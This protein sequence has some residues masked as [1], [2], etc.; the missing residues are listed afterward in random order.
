MAL[1]SLGGI[2]WAPSPIY[3]TPPAFDTSGVL[4]A[5]ADRVAWI[6]MCDRALTVDQIAVSFGA[7]ATPAT[8]SFRIETL[9]GSPDQPSGA[10]WATN[11]EATPVTPVANSVVTGTLTANASIGIRTAFAVVVQS[12][13]TPINVIINRVANTAPLAGQFPYGATNLT[14]SYSLSATIPMIGIHD[15]IAGWVQLGEY[16]LPVVSFDGPAI[17]TGTGATTGTRRGVR[18]SIP[19]PARLA[20]IHPRISY[21]TNA[22]WDLILYD[23][24]GGA[25]Q[26]MLSVVGDTQRSSGGGGGFELPVNPYTIAANT[27][28]KLAIVPTTANSVTLREAT[29]GSG[30]LSACP[31]GT[32]WQST[33]YISSAWSVITDSHPFISLGFDQVDNGASAG[34]LLTHP[35]MAGGMR[36]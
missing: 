21:L 19:V 24:S 14:G 34:G 36:G 31:M 9:S 6:G 23:D 32:N 18:F 35:G 17:N 33:A 5:S 13:S 27:F 8:A 26:T 4:D 11:T 20:K 7:C 30:M 25:L 1:V 29:V 22:D 10:L 3:Q 2:F 28:Y 15:T 12:A 16:T